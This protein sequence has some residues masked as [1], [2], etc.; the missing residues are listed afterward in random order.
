MAGEAPFSDVH[1]RTNRLEV[2]V[3]SVRFLLAGD[4]VGA[5]NQVMPRTL[6]ASAGGYCYHALNRGN[7]RSR[8]FHD[9]DD[10]N[11][12]VASLRAGCARVPMRLI[13]FCVLPNH[14]HLVLRPYEDG[15]LSVWMQWLLTSHAHGYRKRYRGSGHVWQGRFR[16]FPIEENQHLLTVLRYVER[17]PLRA[18]LVTH[19]QD[20][21]GRAFPYVSI[22]R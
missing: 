21:H 17:N 22:R 2:L 9:A 4:V 6:R 12:F 13:G 19:A 7:E 18:G 8:V 10:C 5:D 11:A 15:D 14:F 16:S 3:D 1:A 20:W